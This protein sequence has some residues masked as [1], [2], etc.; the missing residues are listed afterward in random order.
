MQESCQERG[1][2]FSSRGD[3]SLLPPA[4][5]PCCLHCSTLPAKPLVI[6]RLVPP[7]PRYG[8]IRWRA[9]A[10]CV[11]LRRGVGLLGLITPVIMGRTEPGKP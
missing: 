6:P 4:R 5:D 11:G 7:S 9:R 2:S 10:H 1:F 3:C 8:F